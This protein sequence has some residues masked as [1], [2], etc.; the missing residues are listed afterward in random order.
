M[1]NQNKR[2]PNFIERKRQWKSKM[3]KP[4]SGRMLLML[5]P[6]LILSVFVIMSAPYLKIII[7]KFLD[8]DSMITTPSELNLEDEEV[9]EKAGPPPNPETV[10]RDEYRKRLEAEGFDWRQKPQ[11]DPVDLSFASEQDHTVEAIDVELPSTMTELQ[12]RS[13]PAETPSE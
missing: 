3:E 9:V 4:L 13:K 8:E 11:I 12:A 5:M 2:E 10:M 6:A 1:L 7:E